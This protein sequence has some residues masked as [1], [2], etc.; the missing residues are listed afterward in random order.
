MIVMIVMMVC[1]VSQCVA[2]GVVIFDEGLMIVI[3]IGVLGWVL[4]VSAGGFVVVVLVV[5]IG[6]RCC[7]VLG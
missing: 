6:D 2:L 1:M 3:L 5:A 7:A 4:V